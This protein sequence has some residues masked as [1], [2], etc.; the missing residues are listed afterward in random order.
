MFLLM[1]HTLLLNLVLRLFWLF[2]EGLL[3]HINL[4]EMEL[5]LIFLHLEVLIYLGKTLGVIGT[6]KIGKML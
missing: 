5:V 6:G 2:Q 3:S 4:S 1:V